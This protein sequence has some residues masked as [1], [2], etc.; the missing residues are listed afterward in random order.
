MYTGFRMGNVKENHL[1]DLG[2]NGNTILKRTEI[3]FL[4]RRGLD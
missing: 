1:E 4:R 3:N 2:V